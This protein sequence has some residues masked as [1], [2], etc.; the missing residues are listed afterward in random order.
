[1]PDIIFKT[2]EP[3][4]G[5]LEE[6]MP[7]TKCV[8]EYYKKMDMWVHEP[9]VYNHNQLSS[10]MTMKACIPVSYTHLTLPTKA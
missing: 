3:Y 2:W 5:T 7:A 9:K 4:F 10:G 1:M 8:P 6:P